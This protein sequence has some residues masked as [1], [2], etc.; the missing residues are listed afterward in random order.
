MKGHTTQARQGTR[1]TKSKINSRQATVEEEDQKDEEEPTL[2]DTENELSI[3]VAHKS[4]LYTDD[5][6]RFPVR[7]R[8]GNQ[9]IMV[10]YH[11]SN[12]ILAQP[13]ISRKDKHRMA[14]YDAII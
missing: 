11:S 1:S 10:G 6:G 8:A 9:Y 12:L 2:D 7:S 3:K 14:A 4:K 5:S 13:F